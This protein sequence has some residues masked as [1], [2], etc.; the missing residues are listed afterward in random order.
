M[1]GRGNLEIPS[2]GSKPRIL[3]FERPAKNLGWR[4]R[5]PLTNHRVTADGL[6]NFDLRH[7]ENCIG[8]ETDPCREWPCHI[9]LDSAWGL[10]LGY[11]SLSF[12]S[13]PLLVPRACTGHASP[14]FQS[15]ANLSQLSRR[16]WWRM[17]VTI[18]PEYPACRAGDHPMRPLH[19]IPVK[20]KAPRICLWYS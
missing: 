16:T 2:R 12:Q 7:H 4:V 6:Q 19:H 17:W 5:V 13:L 10:L 20:P 15:G 9:P 3:P 11:T 14:P 1:A 18:P 8:E